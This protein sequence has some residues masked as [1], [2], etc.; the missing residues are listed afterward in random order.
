MVQPLELRICY[1]DSLFLPLP[2]LLKRQ[3]PASS[4]P[5][6]TLSSVSLALSL[7]LSLFSSITFSLPYLPNTHQIN[8]PYMPLKRV[9]Y[10][11][12]QGNKMYLSRTKDQHWQDWD[13]WLRYQW[14][15]KKKNPLVWCLR[16]GC[17]G[18]VSLKCR[19]YQPLFSKLSNRRQVR[20][21]DDTDISYGG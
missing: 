14:F 8:S 10:T 16:G 1:Q 2:A 21:E 19:A 13:K 4:L 17:R 11:N 6:P 7:F 15:L 20:I 5:T 3:L 12:S 18:R 9:C